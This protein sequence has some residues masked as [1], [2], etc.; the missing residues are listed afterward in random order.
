MWW[1]LTRGGRVERFG[2]VV[3]YGRDK[4]LRKVSVQ[5]N[6]DDGGQDGDKEGLPC[7]CTDNHINTKIILEHQQE[8]LS[9]E[10]KKSC[11][12]MKKCSLFPI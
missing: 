6:N 1:G 10:H 9:H 11:V 3:G 4:S 8:H 2:A 5:C 12:Y 7:Q